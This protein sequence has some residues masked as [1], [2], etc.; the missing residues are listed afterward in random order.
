MDGLASRVKARAAELGFALS[1]IAPAADADGFDHF[2]AWLDRGYAGAMGYLHDLREPRRHPRGVLPAVRS[3]L[4]VGLEYGGGDSGPTPH[5]AGRVAKYAAG[6]DYHR[7]V[8]DRI[9]ELAA[10]L[11]GAAPGCKTEAVADTA[12]LLERDF[13]RRAEAEPE[14]DE[15]MLREIYSGPDFAEGVR[16]FLA[17]EK[18]AFTR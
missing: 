18:P 7:F 5:P 8:W 2:S 12:P 16:A 3:V 4:M 6:P 9:N 15:A 14:G 11:E 17:K 1:G 10:W 13:A